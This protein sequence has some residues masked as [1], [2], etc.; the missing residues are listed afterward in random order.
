MDD[1]RLR[2]IPLF[3]GLSKGEC[4]MIGRMADEVDVRDGERLMGEGKLAYEFFAIERGTCEVTIHGDRVAELGPGDFL[5]EIGA[6][7]HARRNATVTATSP[8]TVIVMTARD[9]R[10]IE[11]EM[12]AVHDRLQA[13]IEERV[14]AATAGNG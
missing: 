11:H 12:P 14:A 10:F 7:S 1:A 13:A 8:M 5:G 3:A 4:R 6:V 2:S 9:L